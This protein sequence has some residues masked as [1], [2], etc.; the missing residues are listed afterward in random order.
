VAALIEKR[1]GVRYHPQS[2]PGLLQR[3]K[4][5]LSLSPAVRGD[6]RPSPTQCEVLKAALAQP[7]SAAGLQAPRWEQR[8][9]AQFLKSRFDLSYPTRGLY[10]RI[11][12]WGVT[13]PTPAVAGGACSLTPEQRA[14]LAAAL[15]VPPASC[16]Y[17]A[18]AWS[19][20]LVAQFI[21]ER[22]SIRYVC[23]SIP[24]VLRRDGLRLRTARTLDD[25][26]NAPPAVSREVSPPFDPTS[27]VPV[28][29]RPPRISLPKPTFGLRGSTADSAREP[30]S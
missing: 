27:D 28:I 4:I 24:H 6:A 5:A 25:Q 17:S 13:I 3:W 12:R 20:A 16:G 10:R 22:F 9:I 29:A 19:R 11:Q 14:A 18:R 8:Y 26:G 15:A 23:G 21:L 2:I 30:T 1:F 7:P